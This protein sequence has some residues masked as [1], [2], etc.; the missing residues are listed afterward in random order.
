MQANITAG[1]KIIVPENFKFRSP[2]QVTAKGNKSHAWLIPK[3]MVT[4]LSTHNLPVDVK[5]TVCHV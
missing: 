1:Y 2:T 4:H 3:L 5:A